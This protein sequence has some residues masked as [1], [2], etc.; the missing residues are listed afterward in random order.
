MTSYI[1]E[2]NDFTT[3]LLSVAGLSKKDLLIKD[4][5]NRDE[6]KALTELWLSQENSISVIRK[7]TED[8]QNS[9][10]DKMDVLVLK[11]PQF[12]LY[13]RKKLRQLKKLKNCFKRE[14]IPR[15]TYF[16]NKINKSIWVCP[17]NDIVNAY[18]VLINRKNENDNCYTSYLT[19]NAKDDVIV[20]EKVL[21]MIKASTDCIGEVLKSIKNANNLSIE[22]YPVKNV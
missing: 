1:E 3:S 15:I 13:K 7:M 12:S 8:N 21:D 16:L 18:I 20:A 4:K 2:F 11:Y 9:T 17:S 22:V 10:D 19:F 5:N 6:N 14:K